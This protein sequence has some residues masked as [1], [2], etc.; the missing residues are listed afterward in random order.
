MTRSILHAAR[1]FM[2]GSL[3]AACVDTSPLD[4]TPDTRDSGV[5]SQ[6]V[7][8]RCRICVTAP[9]GACKADYDACTANE[10]CVAFSDCLFEAACFSLPEL[11]D[12]ITCGTP[13]FEKAKIVSGVDPALTLTYPLNTCTY[14]PGGPCS[15][16]CAPK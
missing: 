15:S 2:A 7:R 4:Y 14:P 3:L 8:A 1:G 5:V 6:E 9:D 10:R 12:R 11:Q 13:C 16:A